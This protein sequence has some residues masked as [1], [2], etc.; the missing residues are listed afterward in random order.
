MRIPI[1]NKRDEII[2]HKER[3]DRNK[4]DITRVAALLLLNPKGETLITRR[5]ANKIHDP[6]KW[7]PAVAGT[8][9]EGETYIANIIKETL[10]EIGFTI[11]EKELLVGPHVYIETDH[12]YF[13][14]FYFAKTDLPISAFNIDPQ[15]VAEIRWAV[16]SE[17]I[18]WFKKSPADFTRSFEKSIAALSLL[19][20]EKP[21]IV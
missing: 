1:V 17:L 16:I 12:K 7:G 15:E 18:A 9:E 2:G 8:V 13:T 3:T 4:T 21:F 6:N 10:E 11:T 5:A 14:Q 19:N 20:G